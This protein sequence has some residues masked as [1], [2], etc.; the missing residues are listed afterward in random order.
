MSLL[1][2]RNE[3][4]TKQLNF[5]L[6]RAMQF[7]HWSPQSEMIMTLILSITNKS[8]HT[9]TTPKIIFQDSFSQ[10]SATRNIF[11]HFPQFFFFQFSSFEIGIWQTTLRYFQNHHQLLF[12]GQKKLRSTHWAFRLPTAYFMIFFNAP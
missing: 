3:T 11:N 12:T 2:K 10:N 1:Y 4:S 7:Y 6:K 9:Q 5:M 8:M